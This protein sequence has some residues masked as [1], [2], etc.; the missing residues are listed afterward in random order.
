MMQIV[1]SVVWISQEY[2]E[3]IVCKYTFIM[4]NQNLLA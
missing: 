4:E 2:M 3:S 1:H